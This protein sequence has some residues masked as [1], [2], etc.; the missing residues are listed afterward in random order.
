MGIDKPNVRFVVHY[1]V[2]KNVES[3]YQELGRCGRDGLAAEALLLFGYADV[4]LARRL[5]ETSNNAE[6]VRIESHKLNRM[7]AYAESQTCRRRSLLNYFGDPLE[8]DCGN[9][10]V[11]LNPPEQYEATL[12]ARMALSCVYRVDQRFGMQHVIDVL[13]G[14]SNQRM[15]QWGHHRLS[16]YGIGQE[17]SKADWEAL[18]WQ[19]IHR[20]YLRQDLA[21]YSVLQLT[22]RARPLLAGEEE[23]WLAKR[24][25]VKRP[26]KKKRS[27]GP[28]EHANAEPLTEE[29]HALFDQLRTL[30][31][32]LAKGRPAYTVFSD[33]SLLDMVRRRPAG[34]GAFL[35]VKGVGE[36]KLAQYG[37]AFLELINGS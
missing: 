32:E 23:I 18:F 12:A 16:T 11:C 15:D 5:I 37:A 21:R 22:E 30:R 33:A 13:R 36:H 28:V 31:R 6:Q 27:R 34:E 24:R 1:D 25:E 9:C 3:Y 26:A 29:E 10:D 20:G 2:P 35:D 19:L 8:E 17:T 14:S 4:V 7:V